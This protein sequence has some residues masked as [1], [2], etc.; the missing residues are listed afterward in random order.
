MDAGF[1]ALRGIE[2]L[3]ARS[4]T[5]ILYRGAR[6]SKKCCFTVLLF[7]PLGSGLPTD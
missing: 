3:L 1:S 7:L 2:A 5:Q 6:T 4:L